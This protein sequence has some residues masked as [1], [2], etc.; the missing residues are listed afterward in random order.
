M[1][2]DPAQLVPQGSNVTPEHQGCAI[3]GAGI[4]A[5]SVPGAD[6][7]GTSYEYTRSH[8]WRN[9]AVVIAL[10]VL[11]ILVTLVATETFSFASAGGGALVFKKSKRAK[12][13]VKQ[14]EKVQDDVESGGSRTSSQETEVEGG[15][16]GNA[17]ESALE[18]I[19]GG[20]SVF[21]WEDVCYTVPY[22]GGERQL[23]NHVNGYAKP[24]LMVALMGA[25]G[26][27]KTTLLN[28][29]SQRQNTGVVSGDMLV[30][31]R[32][33]GVEFKRG[34]GFCEQMDLHD[35]SIALA[36]T[37]TPSSICVTRIYSTCA[38]TVGHVAPQVEPRARRSVFVKILLTPYSKPQQ[39]ARLSNSLQS[40]VK[41]AAYPSPRRS[42][43]STR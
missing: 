6:Y 38:E 7:I 30:D 23:L 17:D 13:T 32:A 15:N 35:V 10:T 27:G 41:I 2:C 24:G 33:L 26:A 18:E 22:Q 20:E 5:Q 11:Y 39:S 42:P 19:S 8:L 9:F 29:L 28:T 40:S 16:A 3:T 4:N 43:M 37:I 31:G 36:S 25:S 1:A 12:Q 14:S 21:T 34:T